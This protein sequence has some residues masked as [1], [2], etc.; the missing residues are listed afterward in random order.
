ML[1][2]RI[3]YCKPNAKKKEKPPLTRMAYGGG[4]KAGRAKT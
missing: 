2:P 1:T 4:E 3:N